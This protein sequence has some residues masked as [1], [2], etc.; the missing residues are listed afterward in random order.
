MLGD[1]E[2]KVTSVLGP[3]HSAQEV[4]EISGVLWDY[5]PFAISIEL[6]AGKVYSIRVA[7][8]NL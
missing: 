6:V 2:E 8:E 1:S 4:K 5:H 3:R 7:D